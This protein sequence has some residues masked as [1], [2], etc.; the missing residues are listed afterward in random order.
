LASP[1]EANGRLTLPLREA[2][3]RCGSRL[4]ARDGVVQRTTVLRLKDRADDGVVVGSDGE[5]NRL[6]GRLEGAQDV[7]VVRERGVR[8]LLP[9]QARIGGEVAGLGVVLVRQ[10]GRGQTL[11]VRLQQ[12][13]RQR[14]RGGIQLRLIRWIRQVEGL[15]RKQVP[16]AGLLGLILGVGVKLLP[17]LLERKGVLLD[18]CC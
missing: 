15:P 10:R 4:E 3:G 17:A 12:T 14:R 13:G 8:R 16:K 9:G 1:I 11:L 2:L 5:V 7:L 6:V 18:A